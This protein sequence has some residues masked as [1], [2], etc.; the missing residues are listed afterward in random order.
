[1]RNTGAKA[2]TV[3]RIDVSCDCIRL[4]P[5]PTPVRPGAAVALDVAYDPAVDPDYLG[6][7]GV[8][9][10]GVDAAG[11]VVFRTTVDVVVR[12]DAR[13][14]PGGGRVAP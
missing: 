3:A 9:L 1:L 14:P 12:S 11:V 6:I 2:V 7:L 13:E 5:P 8:E 10:T 4:S